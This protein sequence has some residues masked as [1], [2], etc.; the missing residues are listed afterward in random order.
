[1]PENHLNYL[2]I[3]EVISRSTVARLKN[4]LRDLH[5]PVG[6]VKAVLQSRLE[7]ELYRRVSSTLTGNTLPLAQMREIVNGWSLVSDVVINDPDIFIRPILT[8]RLSTELKQF[9]LP[10]PMRE[11]VAQT[12]A[13]RLYLRT[14]RVLPEGDLSETHEWPYLT[15]VHTNNMGCAPITQPTARPKPHGAA[16]VDMV[17]ESL[18]LVIQTQGFTH[19]VVL[20]PPVPDLT[21]LKC[22]QL[23]VT[24]SCEE[25]V[26]RVGA[27]PRELESVGRQHIQDAMSGA[28]FGEDD[29]IEL[30]PAE[31]LDFA[32]RCAV[33]LGRL[34]TPARGVHC[35]HSE[36]FDLSSLIAYNSACKTPWK[37]TVCS[38]S[39]HPDDLVVD[40]FLLRVVRECA[41]DRVRFAIDAAGL[42]TYAALEQQGVDLMED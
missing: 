39:V 15:H 10:E 26:A 18:P 20:S 33:G 40:T 12:P 27:A 32:L 3:L 37:C 30:V 14:F 25:V 41:S 19:G 11:A 31:Y 2:H 1:M 42:V 38:K 36:C 16:G 7:G 35:S 8:L 29:E 13:L 28:Q 21:Y 6:G 4:F 22:L 24:V 34:A 9:D 5:L 23:A 17:G